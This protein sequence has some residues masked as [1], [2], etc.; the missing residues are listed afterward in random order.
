MASEKEIKVPEIRR[1]MAYITVEG[2]APG[3]MSGAMPEDALPEAGDEATA[4]SKKPKLPPDIQAELRRHRLNPER[5]GCTDGI[6]SSAFAGALIGAVR[7]T[8]MHMTEARGIFYI[9]GGGDGLIP[10]QGPPPQPLTLTGKNPNKRS[11]AVRITRPHW[12]TWSATVPVEYNP[13]LISLPELVALFR[14]AGSV[15]GV[16][17]GRPEKVPGL[18]FGRFSVPR[19]GIDDKGEV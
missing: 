6:P 1:A 13:D 11:V 7:H 2:I 14:L 4:R 19:D 3:Y 16:G 15:V 12:R 10:I 18:A 9:I 8:K 17:E 5:D